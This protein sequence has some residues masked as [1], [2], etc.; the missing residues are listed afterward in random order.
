MP[1]N[2][3]IKDVALPG[4]VT[5]V[6]HKTNKVSDFFFIYTFCFYLASIMHSSENSIYMKCLFRVTSVIN[7][8]GKYANNFF[9]LGNKNKKYHIQSVCNVWIYFQITT[10]APEAKTK[11]NICFNIVWKI[12]A[13]FL[14][15]SSLIKRQHTFCL[16]SKVLSIS[17]LG[18]IEN[19]WLKRFH[20]YK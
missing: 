4:K 1:L 20:R 17:I 16:K 7:W 12:S 8:K 6:S 3:I 18:N 14:I 13:Q 19:T 5:T 9:T 10:K 15:Y 2:Y 11:E